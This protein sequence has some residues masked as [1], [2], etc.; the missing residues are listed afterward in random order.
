MLGDESLHDLFR[1]QVIRMFGKETLVAQMPPTAHHRQIQTNRAIQLRQ[2]N[3]VCIGCA[4]GGFDELFLL[5]GVQCPQ[6][7]AL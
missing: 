5:Y 7:V 3:D 2:R 6:L 4:A 1:R